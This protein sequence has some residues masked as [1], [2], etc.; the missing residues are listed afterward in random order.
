MTSHDNSSAA[1]RPK[2]ARRSDLFIGTKPQDSSG[3]SD[4]QHR[5]LVSVFDLSASEKG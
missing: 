3:F 5:R 2:I 1:A 4:D